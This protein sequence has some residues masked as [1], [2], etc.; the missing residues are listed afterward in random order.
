MGKFC[1]EKE[2]RMGTAHRVWL[3]ALFGLG[4]LLVGPSRARAVVGLGSCVTGVDVCVGNSGDVG[5]KSCSGDFACFDNSGRIHNLACLGFQACA[6][7]SGAV[8]NNSCIG[9]D[10]CVDSSGAVG[11]HSCTG[12]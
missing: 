6:A 7:H 5:T 4:L 1:P 9:V 2:E 11:T 10:A 8:N 3:S 12:F